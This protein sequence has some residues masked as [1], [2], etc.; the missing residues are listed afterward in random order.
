M[1]SL[2]LLLIRSVLLLSQRYHLGIRQQTIEDWDA[3][4]DELRKRLGISNP[5]IRQIK[6][7][8][9]ND[10]KRVVFAEAENYKM[11]KETEEILR[12]WYKHTVLIKSEYKIKARQ[13]DF[14]EEEK[15]RLRSLG[16][17]D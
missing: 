9:K 13:A 14:T 15:Q 3:Y 4:R 8:A 11:L 5:L 2:H 16:Y 6:T 10:P 1:Q 12:Q 7:R 17:L